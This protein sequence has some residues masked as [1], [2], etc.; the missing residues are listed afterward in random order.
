MR[1]RLPIRA[2]DR[3]RCPACRAEKGLQSIALGAKA[4]SLTAL[5]LLQNPALLT[6]IKADHRAALAAQEQA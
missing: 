5:E 2:T 3:M 6:S 4:L 1:K